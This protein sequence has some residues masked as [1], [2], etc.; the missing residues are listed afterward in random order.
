[1]ISCRVAEDGALK[2]E[3]PWDPELVRAAREDG[4]H[5]WV[6]DWDGPLH[7][8]SRGGDLV[9]SLDLGEEAHHLA[10]TPDGRILVTTQTGTLRV[11]ESGAL[12]PA[13]A[14]DLSARVCDNRERGLLGGDLASEL[15]QV[16]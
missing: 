9:R 8:I 15:R 10:F 14:L 2:R 16:R 3:V 4:R 1:M 12:L 13:P 11:V 5:V 7:V 6:T